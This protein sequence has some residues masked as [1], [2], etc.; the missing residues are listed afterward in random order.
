[1]LGRDARAGVGRAFSP[2]AR[3]LVR[4]HITPDAITWVGTI[5]TCGLAVALLVPGHFVLGALLITVVVLA[6]SLDGLVA[7]LT[8]TSSPW[9]AFLDS[10]LDRIA[11]G[12]VLG[13]LAVHFL[14][15]APRSG[16]TI[17]CGVLALVALVL[18]GAVS[19][20]KAR[21]ESLSMTADVGLMERADRFVVILVGTLVTGLVGPWAMLVAMVVLVAGSAW[22]VAQRMGAVHRQGRRVPAAGE[23]PAVDTDPEG[24]RG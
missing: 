9:G 18:G 14:A 4:L 13:A 17:A 16:L 8:G 19:Y 1:M 23:R 20:A 10:T 11:D 12:V 24:A 22:T 15:V 2:L 21:A 3:T 5:L 6:D 7:R